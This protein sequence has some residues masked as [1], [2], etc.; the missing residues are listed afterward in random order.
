M[1]K[2]IIIMIGILSIVLLS[3]CSNSSIAILPT[4]INT[5]IINDY[6][7]DI[8]NNINPDYIVGQEYGRNPDIDITTTYEDLW[9]GGGVYP[10][11][12]VTTAE[13]VQ[14]F[15][16]VSSD[17]A[18]G[19]GARTIEL[20]GLNSSYDEITENI[21]MNGVNIVNS[22]KSYIRLQ[23]AKVLTSGSAETNKG[24]ITVRQ[25]ITTANIFCKMPTGY[26]HTMV[27]VYT[28]PRGYN[29][30][31]NSYTM[32]LSS[33][34]SGNVQVRLLAKPYNQTWYVLAENGLYTSGN[35]FIQ[36]EFEYCR[37]SFTEK[38]DI[39]MD[40]ISDSV[41]QAISG[42]ISYILIRK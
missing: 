39:K 20:I 12:N 26:G 17:N 28:V 30:C 41:N 24:D 21:T 5:T 15:S 19:T 6:K 4:E 2:K 3:G 10:G 8:V 37:N 9:N 11:T 16:S 18:T 31:L 38:T 25:S 33:K 23:H 29:L 32:S 36:R 22:T 27:M 7:L 14:I 34:N 35:S 42:S 1:N 40:A 13:I